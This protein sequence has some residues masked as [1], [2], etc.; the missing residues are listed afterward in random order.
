[1]VNQPVKPERVMEIGWPLALYD[2][3]KNP[4]T[5]LPPLYLQPFSCHAM[6]LRNAGSA[7]ESFHV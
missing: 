6:I 5:S 4:V 1:M 2:L 3:R 7:I